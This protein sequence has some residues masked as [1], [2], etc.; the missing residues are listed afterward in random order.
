MGR[1]KRK[2][3]EDHPKV[4]GTHQHDQ[5]KNDDLKHQLQQK[6]ASISKS[7]NVSGD[8]KTK[9]ASSAYAITSH[10]AEIINEDI[11]V[12]DGSESDE[13]LM[14][15]MQQPNVFDNEEGTGSVDDDEQLNRHGNGGAGRS[16]EMMLSGSRMGL[17][18]RG[19]HR[20]STM[21]LLQP[22]RQ[23]AR[24]DNTN[25]S[26]S[27]EEE[28]KILDD[29]GGTEGR[30]KREKE[31]ELAKLDPSER[32]ARLLAEKQRKLE[33]AK[34]LAR[35]LE[36]EENAGRDICLFSKRTSFDIRF[37]QIDDKPWARGGDMTDFFNY[38]FSEEDWLEYGE[39]QL[40]IRQELIDANRQ[41][42]PID[43]SVVPI[44]PRKPK[45]QAA[46]VAVAIGNTTNTSDDSTSIAIDADGKG[47]KAD[48]KD[49]DVGNMNVP[50]VGPVLKKD[51]VA[52]EKATETVVDASTVSTEEVPSEDVVDDIEVVGGAWGAGAAP[53]SFLAKL[54][55]EQEKHQ[56]VQN[57]NEDHEKLEESSV[58]KTNEDK[59]SASYPESIDRCNNNSNSSNQDRHLQGHH[60]QQQSWKQGVHNNSKIHQQQ[61]QGWNDS[62]TQ[63][64]HK[65]ITSYQQQQQGWNDSN[66]QGYHS[67]NKRN[68]GGRHVNDWNA[69]NQER[70]TSYQHHHPQRW[71]DSGRGRG[72]GG[73]REYGGR[74]REGMGRGGNRDEFHYRKRPRDD[75]DDRHR[76]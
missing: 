4:E 13:D 18:R 20:P 35:R 43:P 48:D 16:I 36:S 59:P 26:K 67:N 54:I 23:W 69:R 46:R 21:Q 41:S 1:K 33:E 31:E 30:K 45:K 63:G 47:I 34:I 5:Q 3:V 14:M 7:D 10:S 64:S 61:Q 44:I 28:S 39:Q 40:R 57:K 60:Q 75:Y 32:A 56:Q 71:G 53:G 25:V 2:S 76:R 66:T 73:G 37:D 74:G 65:S 70:V 27:G 68:A 52:E 17:M 6:S 11:Y 9:I 58:S 49:E 42:R 15:N 19:I 8:S 12:S 24:Q 51:E 38:G 72:R 22:N 55:E 62:N 50:I 29:D